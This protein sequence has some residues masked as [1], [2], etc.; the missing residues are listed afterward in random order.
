MSILP[1]RVWSR[2]LTAALSGVLVAGLVQAAPTLGSAAA[3]VVHH[4]PA[5]PHHLVASFAA[6]TGPDLA[7]RRAERAKIAERN[8]E[9][10]AARAPVQQAPAPADERPIFGSYSA[11][12]LAPGSTWSAGGSSGS[13]DWSYPMRVPQP[14]AGPTP[15]LGLT[16]DS[17]SVDGRTLATNNQGS[18]VGEGFELTSTSYISRAYVSCH[19]DGH[20]ASKD[21]C[22]NSAQATLVL[23]GQATLLV[24]DGNSPNLY[25]LAQDD[26]TRVELVKPGSNPTNPEAGEYWK[27]TT[28]DGTEYDFGRNKLPGTGSSNVRTDSVDSVPVFG[29]D[30]GEPCNADTFA[31]SECPQAWQWNLDYVVDPTGNAMTYWY[32]T[33]TN[34]YLMNGDTLTAYDAGTHLTEIDYGLRSDDLFT[35]GQPTPAPD[36]VV[37]TA[38]QRCTE[39]ASCG[40]APNQYWRD[41]PVDAICAAGGSCTSPSPS[42][43]SETLLKK[44]TTSVM[45]SGGGYQQAD[46]WTLTPTFLKPDDQTEKSKFAQVLWLSSLQHTGEDGNE[47]SLPAEQ[48]TPTWLANRVDDNLDDLPP[49]DRPRLET[50]QTETGETI[51]VKY[52]GVDCTPGDLPSPGDNHRMCYP[53]YWLDPNTGQQTLEWFNKYDVTSVEESDPNNPVPSP[54]IRTAYTYTHPSWHWADSPDQHYDRTT[55]SQWR[56][57]RQVDT[58]VGQG[59]QASLT[60][61]IY[62]QGMDDDSG[63]T[64]VTGIDAPQMLDSNQYAGF[65]REHVVYSS[66]T[67]GAPG[68]RVSDEYYAPWDLNTATQDFDAHGKYDKVTVKSWMIRTGKD[69]TETLLYQPA[70]MRTRLVQTDYNSD[71]F[72][73]AVSDH[74]DT[75]HG[76]DESC[77]T[78]WYAK[79]AAADSNLVDLP[80][81]V[82]TLDLLCADSAKA[83]LPAH[84]HTA[85]DVISDTATMYDNATGWQSQQVTEGMPTETDRVTGYDADGNPAGWQPTSTN[86]Y[87]ALGRLKKTTD[88]ESHT[89]TTTYD[90]AGAGVPNKVTV[91]K[92]LGLTTTTTLDPVWGS[93]T[94]VQDPNGNDTLYQYDA[95][96][97]LTAVWM[98]SNPHGVA[99]Q[100]FG[101]HVSNTAASWESTSTFNSW[102]GD[103]TTDYAFYDALLRQI[104]T[105]TIPANLDKTQTLGRL[106]SQTIYGQRGNV[107]KQ[108][109]DMYDTSSLPSSTMV[110]VSVGG[111][112]T[113]I[114]T[115]YDNANRPTGHTYVYNDGHHTFSTR[116]SYDGRSVLTTAPHGGSASQTFTDVLGRTTQVRVYGDEQGSGDYRST[117]TSY[118]P[119]GEVGTITGPD[120]AETSYGY[121]LYGRTISQTDPDSGTTTMG[122]DDL[123]QLTRVTDARGEVVRYDYDNLGRKKTEWVGAET[124]DNQ[125]AAWTYD[126]AVNGK[127]L[128]ASSTSYT[129]GLSGPAYTKTVDSYDPLGQPKTTTITL[130]SDDDLVLSGAVPA[131]GA[132]TTIDYSASDG[133]VEDVKNPA[134]GGLAFHSTSFDYNTSGMPISADDIYGASYEPTGQ[135]D[136]E[137]LT[138]SPV[139]GETAYLNNTYEP[140][141]WRLIESSVVDDVHDAGPNGFLDADHTYTYDDAG[142]LLEDADPTKLAGSGD[143]EYRCYT[144]NGYRE[145]VQAW[146]PSH[147]SDTCDPSGRSVA[148]LAGAAPYWHSFTYTTSGQ[149]ATFTDHGTGGATTTDYTYGGTPCDGTDTTSAHVLT[150]TTIEG[151]GSTNYGCDAAGNTT[152]RPGP[153]NT[154]SLTWDGANRLTGIDQAATGS[155]P[156]THTDNIYDADG[157]LLI[158]RVTSSGATT[159]TLFDGWN[160]VHAIKHRSGSYAVSGERFIPFAGQTAEIGTVQPDGTAQYYFAFPD[161][162]GTT[163]LL[164]QH[165]ASMTLTK[166]YLLPFGGP[167]GQQPSWPDDRGFLDKP[168]ND[169]TA[170]TVLGARFYD[171]STGAFISH[172]PVTNAADPLSLNNY[173]YADSN[174]LTNLDPDGTM[175]RDPNDNGGSSRDE[176]SQPTHIGV[177]GGAGQGASGDSYL[178]NASRNSGDSIA[179]WKVNTA[180]AGYLAE[181]RQWRA[182]QA[183]LRAQQN[184]GGGWL[185]GAWGW[186]S[187]HK[188]AIGYG[189]LTVGLTAVNAVQFGADPLT[190]SAEALAAGATVEAIEGGAEAGE[191]ITVAGEG[192][193]E[194]AG[195]VGGGAARS[196]SFIVKPNGET[197]IVPEGAE[198]PFPV[199]SGKGF[200]FRGGSGGHGLSDSASDV[201]I[202]DPVTGGKYPKPNGY[203]SYL[204][205]G[206]QTINPFTGQTVGKADPWWHWEFLP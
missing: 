96:G 19:D 196:P 6:P 32:D 84:P 28:A 199:E 57:F 59:G 181:V 148:N 62:M 200:M 201:R 203:A 63:D 2:S 112:P 174:P 147:S 191:A 130:P 129:S 105:Q 146:T 188:A 189:A 102:T 76:G 123:D 1:G 42:F 74:G 13:F 78:T 61:D 43:F 56:G 66:G 115:A 30:Q 41:V 186:V 83:D 142:N 126:S 143:S 138:G 194:T 99:Y 85:G 15:Q 100:K 169:S 118:L 104:Q 47:I 198:G 23:N 17:G 109:D 93:P 91:E 49:I 97:R 53:S 183:A 172:D 122:Y 120:Q 16:Y 154:E 87:D 110:G 37:F 127:G 163:E 26:G 184:S 90:P 125:I 95:L 168:V 24:R 14:A 64:Y 31:A 20:D 152:S 149:R 185:S 136:G 113:E 151:G 38:G 121:D 132:T 4:R 144:Y 72:P 131:A 60:T 134:V 25:H 27:L 3:A 98:P 82:Q 179:D 86:S 158:Q 21:L 197:V 103:Y 133:Q 33:L 187:S 54:A 139:S 190:D 11:T 8:R 51:Q 106:V 48:F 128:L 89:T 81:R 50:I 75:S 167:I 107:A 9:A 18:Q 165:N 70:G 135:L 160:E 58:T 145:L 12:P 46:S 108:Q 68:D 39:G 34:R 150:A 137:T 7:A 94:D 88:V 117:T 45:K 162:H 195:D 22:W 77:T 71:G 161:A 29:D 192:A 80:A 204:N 173:A 156:G 79:P 164:L 119:T 114:D 202:M 155:D 65:Q 101:Y 159:S 73:I 193:A 177:P 52:S 205:R 170:L 180:Y 116:T 124:D 36:R 69:T 92:P 140:G 175:F 178:A 171:P 55:W 206:G 166:R 157:N 111:V 40:D 5:P 176:Q 153:T 182:E 67:P 35:A 141:T 44:I 10:R